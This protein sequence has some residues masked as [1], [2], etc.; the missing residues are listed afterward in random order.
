MRIAH[1]EIRRLPGGGR[2][3]VYTIEL[4]GRRFVV[5]RVLGGAQLRVHRWPLREQPPVGSPLA[6]ARPNPHTRRRRGFG[7]T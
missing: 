4:A 5:T 3:A 7:A 2:L 6:R 1:Y